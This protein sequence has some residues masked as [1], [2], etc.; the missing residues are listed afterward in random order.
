MI[1]GPQSAAARALLKWTLADL[2]RESGLATATLTDFENA[3]RPSSSETIQKITSAFDRAGIMFTEGEGV[4]KRSYE[5]RTLRGRQG[6]WEFYDDIYATIKE[7]GG[8]MLMHNVDESLFTKWLGD[9]IPSH[10]ER[11]HKL[12]NFSQKI[13]IREGDM[14]FA[15]NYKTSE[16]RWADKK[17]FSSMPFYLYGE[18]LA[19]ILFEQDNV[20][21]F[22]IDQ[23]QIAQSYRG[24]FLAA[25]EKAKT[26][27]KDKDK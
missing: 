6:F 19:M 13:I 2:S 21:V 7:T 27:T 15:V 10:R 8:E 18:K 5:I 23:P 26:P 11:M 9:K 14:N 25:W 12:G 16:Y 17:E 4:R 24:L 1:T 20:S 22:I 3:K